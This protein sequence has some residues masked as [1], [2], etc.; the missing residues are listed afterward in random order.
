M[1]PEASLETGLDVLVDPQAPP[2]AGPADRV[3]GVRLGAPRPRPRHR[4]HA[5]RL[6]RAR[7]GRGPVPRAGRRRLARA[8]T[9]ASRSTSPSRRSGS[10]PRAVPYPA[11]RLPEG[12]APTPMSTDTEPDRAA[13]RH[14]GR[15]ARH[16]RRRRRPARRGSEPA[17]PGPER[18]RALRPR[19]A[20]GRRAQPAHRLPGRGRLPRASSTTMHLTDGLAWAIPVVLG[21]DE[22]DAHRLGSG[23]RGRARRRPRAPSPI[24]VLARD[25]DLQARQGEGS[26]RGLPDRRRGPPG[27]E[28]G[29]RR[30]ATTA[31]PARSRCWRCRRTTTSLDVPADAGADARRVRPPRLADRRRVPDPQPDPPGARVHPEVRAR[32]RRRPARPP[33]R[34]RDEGRRRPAGRADAVLRGAVRGLLPEGPRDGER[35]PGGDALR[36]SA[37]GRSGTRSA[38]RTT[39]APTSSW[40]ATTPASGRTTAPTTP[41]RSSRSS[42]RASWASPR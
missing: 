13:R 15:P 42:S 22:A 9:A 1:T 14:P 26:R 17:D 20:R 31:S 2:P 32:D 27:R 3:A 39:A 38:A 34:R 6:A 40:A 29:R 18:A 21:V 25:R 4:L 23:G 36:G 28:G 30:R 37:R 19:D 7:R 33:A 12:K 5:R 35:L 10:W 8:T 11:L 16:R 24:A 41:R